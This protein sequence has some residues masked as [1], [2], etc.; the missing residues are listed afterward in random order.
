MYAV[1]PLRYPGAKWRLNAFVEGLLRKNDLLDGHYIEPFAGG[2]SLALGLLYRQAVNEIHLNDLDRALYAFWH[3]A[4]NHAE[5]FAT[6]VEQTDVD[7]EEW[8]RQKEVQAN[9]P[10]ADLFDL[11]F[12]TFFLNRTNRSGILDA[13][14]IGGKE[15]TGKW[16][17]NARF[18]KAEL[19]H[20]IRRIGSHR[21]QIHVTC[22]DAVDLLA[23]LG[24]DLDEKS[25]VYLDPPYFV[26]G[27]GLY[28]NA[29]KPDDH[30]ALRDAVLEHLDGPWMVSYD[31]V[32]EIRKLYRGLRKREHC[33]NYSAASRREGREVLF[34][35]PDI[36]IPTL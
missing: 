4:V 11:G 17:I 14:V 9:K 26:K 12:S 30:S 7:V 3:S 36:K 24:P 32:P 29:Y 10:L 35:A 20:R 13:G 23:Q 33:L 31:D 2:A 28:L 18:N 34:F 19:A 27:Q 6:R 8:Y 25:F 15:Q 22:S 21:T 16:K 1:S 5:E